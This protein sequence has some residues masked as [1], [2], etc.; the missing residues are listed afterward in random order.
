MKSPRISSKICG[1]VTLTHF[2]TSSVAFSAKVYSEI[3]CIMADTKSTALYLGAVMLPFGF[4]TVLSSPYYAKC[5][6][7]MGEEKDRSSL[8]F[9]SFAEVVAGVYIVKDHNKWGNI[10][11]ILVS[12]VGWGMLA[13]GAMCCMFPEQYLSKVRK[14]GN[15]D[16]EPYIQLMGGALIGVGAY[17][18]KIGLG[19]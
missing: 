4:G 13:E 10:D 6:K 14:T 12:S 3:K 11:E 8:M 2:L 1:E 5:F 7:E 19:K 18:L 17:F 16:Q 15:Y 9:W